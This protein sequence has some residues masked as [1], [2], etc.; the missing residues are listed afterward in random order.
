MLGF[1]ENTQVETEVQARGGVAC[2]RVR[3]GGV[4]AGWSGA[5]PGSRT[6]PA[7]AVRHRDLT[8][9]WDGRY[10]EFV[11]CHLKGKQ[12]TAILIEK[13]EP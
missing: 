4:S 7:R 2:W 3:A 10:Y 9:G 8:E 13:N 6:V 11:V 5:T 1:C 12:G